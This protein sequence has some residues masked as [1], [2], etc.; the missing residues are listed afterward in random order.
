MTACAP[1]FPG[2]IL[3]ATFQIRA[4]SFLNAA[5]ALFSLSAIGMQFRGGEKNREKKHEGQGAESRVFF[6]VFGHN[7]NAFP[8]PCP[9]VGR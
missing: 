8:L 3:R 9:R 5:Q 1:M 7:L 4:V 2:F 6:R